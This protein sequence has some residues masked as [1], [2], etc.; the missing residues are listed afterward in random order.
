M[1]RRGYQGIVAGLTL[2][3][4]GCGGS[5]NSS[6]KPDAKAASIDMGAVSCD[7]IQAGNVDILVY[8]Y[9]M[10]T[11]TCDPATMSS[12]TNLIGVW[13]LF[14]EQGATAAVHVLKPTDCKDVMGT[15]NFGGGT[16]TWDGTCTG[17]TG[18]PSTFMSVAQVKAA[19]G[20]SGGQTVTTVGLVSAIQPWAAGKGGTFYLEDPTGAMSSGIEVYVPKTVGPDAG[21]NAPAVGDLVQVDGVTSLYPAMFGAKQIT[22]T[23]LGNLGSGYKLPAAKAIPIASL[24]NMSTSEDAYEG[25]RVQAEGALTVTNTCPPELRFMKTGG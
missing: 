12:F 20:A 17:I 7:G 19:F 4:A 16:K 11:A 21:G 18:C 5:S 14:A 9:S 1:N 23:S 3:V 10:N 25:M 22:A 6:G 15:D 8:P 24:S 2:A 13:D